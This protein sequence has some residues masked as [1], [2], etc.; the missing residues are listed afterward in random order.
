MVLA[1]FL[2]D[3]SVV[4][5]GSILGRNAFQRPR[6]EGMATGTAPRPQVAAAPDV[7]ALLADLAPCDTPT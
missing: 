7:A 4:G 6:A 1:L 3:V 2:R 5:F